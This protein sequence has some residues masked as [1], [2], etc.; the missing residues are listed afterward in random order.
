MP[1]LKQALHELAV[2]SGTAAVLLAVTAGLAAAGPGY[3]LSVV[4][5][6]EDHPAWAAAR[7][8]SRHT[9]ARGISISA[10]PTAPA[11]PSSAPALSVLPVRTL[12]SRLPALQVLE[13]PFLFPGLTAVHAALDGALGE[14]LREHARAAGWEIL[15]FWD[16]GMQAMSGNRRYDRAINLTGMEFLLLRED[17]VAERQ[18]LAL[19]AWTRITN[20]KT[21]EEL[22]RECLV[23]SRAAT[24]QQLAR[25]QVFRVHLDLSLT[26][27]RYE[28]WL[29]AAPLAL[30][31]A[32][33]PAV[34]TT[35]EVAAVDMRAWQRSDAAASERAALELL[36][37]ERM[38][39]YALDAAQRHAFKQRIGD[40]AQMLPARLD[41][42]SWARLVRLATG[43]AAG[44]VTPRTEPSK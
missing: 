17:P 20:P 37:S 27:H 41:A 32:M 15:A 23:G 26:G 18:F 11:A 44:V 38:Q 42:E 24:L 34:R 16:E 3:R 21:R 8:F 33:P 6:D 40:V 1:G 25:E 28:G 9:K 10:N 13:L 43:G 35:L 5:P 29:L 7:Q 31:Q 4:V 36:R 12:A 14:A 2:C 19:E 30:W 22:L 39:V